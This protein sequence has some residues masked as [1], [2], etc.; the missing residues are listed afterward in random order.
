[1]NLDGCTMEPYA[2]GYCA[3][4][5]GNEATLEE[6]QAFH[7]ET[8]LRVWGPASI[9]DEASVDL[10]VE[11]GVELITCNNPDEILRILREKGLHK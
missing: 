11:M 5:F 8:G 10:A 1:M 9:R 6:V 2:F 7:R 4:V 3:C